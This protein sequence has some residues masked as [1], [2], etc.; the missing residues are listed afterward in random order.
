MRRSA[1][2]QLETAI[3]A[4]AEAEREYRRGRARAYVT[5]EAKTAGE[6]DSKVDDM[7]ADLRYVRDVKK[8]LVD[9]AKEK[10]AEVDGERASFHR[11]LEWSMRVDAFAQ[12]NREPRG[13]A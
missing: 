2:A 7:A 8:G 9:A 6:R 10:L 3:E 5:V 12:E 11:L 4:H 1:R 13:G